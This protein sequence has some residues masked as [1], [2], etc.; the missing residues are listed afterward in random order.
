MW[1]AVTV[2]GMDVS[3]PNNIDSLVLEGDWV[4]AFCVNIPLVL[5]SK[6]NF[7][8]YTSASKRSG[9]GSFE[10]NVGF[11]VKAARP[12]SWLPLNRTIPVSDR[13]I[14]VSYICAQ[15]NIDVSNY[16]KSIL[17]ACEGVLYVSDAS[18]QACSA[19]GIRGSSSSFML[20]FA[21]VAPRSTPLQVESALRALMVSAK[22]FFSLV[23]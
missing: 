19:L 22:D 1:Y 12:I 18:V 17:D 9:S 2:I 8:R 3:S 4:S 13:P 11:L 14:V 5:E 7:R 21:Q 10:N 6:S 16:S 20:A 23:R 15:S